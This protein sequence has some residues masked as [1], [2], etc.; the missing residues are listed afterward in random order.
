MCRAEFSAVIV[1]TFTAKEF[2]EIGPF[3]HLSNH[4]FQSQEFHKFLGYEAHLFFLFLFLFFWK[5]SK[6]NVESKH[7]IKVC[8]NIVHFVNNCIWSGTGEFSLIQQKYL[9]TDCYRKTCNSRANK[10]I[11]QRKFICPKLTIQALEKVVKY[12]QCH[13][14]RHRNDAIDVVLVYLLITEQHW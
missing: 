6:F 5:C 11:S 9:S 3:M 2:S 1:N 12:L 13:Q 4:V 8:L 14:K 10:M 7:T